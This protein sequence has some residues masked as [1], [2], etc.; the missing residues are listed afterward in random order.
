ALGLSDP[1]PT[2]WAYVAGLVDGEG[3]IAVIRFYEPRRERYYYGIT[4]VIANTDRAVL[5]WIQTVWGGSVVPARSAGGRAK[6]SWAWRS[7]TTLARTFLR[8]VRPWLRIKSARCEDV[9]LMTDVLQ[10]SRNTLGRKR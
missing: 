7:S 4:V 5:E 1:L 3:C 9:F 10:K 6:S 2:D 8:G